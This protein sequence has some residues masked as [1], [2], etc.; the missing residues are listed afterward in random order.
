MGRENEIFTRWGTFLMD[1]VEE[2]RDNIKELF[3]EQSNLKSKLEGHLQVADVID[4][5][6]KEDQEEI[7]LSIKELSE[8]I[9]K[10]TILVKSNEAEKNQGKNW[11]Q[12]IISVVA[13]LVAMGALYQSCD[14]KIQP[15]DSGVK[16]EST[17]SG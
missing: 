3:R 5:Q 15:K 14:P 2:N 12:V 6:R 16:N 4:K 7:K 17:S 11:V 1:Q 8:K 10:L 9:E 13:V